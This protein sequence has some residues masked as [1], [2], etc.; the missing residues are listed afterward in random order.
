VR[1]TVLGCKLHILRERAGEVSR[2]HTK[3]LE[4][5]IQSLLELN[6]SQRGDHRHD[7]QRLKTK[8]GRR[9]E[10]IG[11]LSKRRRWE[12]SS[13]QMPVRKK[14]MVERQAR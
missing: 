5:E 7:R 3:K 9:E 10:K 14:E 1:G 6:R 2:G 12:L 8:K 13:A 4:T 11:H